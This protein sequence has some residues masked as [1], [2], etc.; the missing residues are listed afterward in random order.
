MMSIAAV[1][2]ELKTAKPDANVYFDFGGCVPT[3]VDSW[4]GSYAEP[5]I[6]WE[7]S[8]YTGNGKPPTVT[9]LMAEL[10]R[11]TD[12]REYSGWKGGEYSYSDSN[13]L[14]VD[15]CGDSTHTEIVRVEVD[16]W[17]VV[18]HTQMLES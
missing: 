10:E 13:T 5:A 16:D 8:G 1:M 3:R 11:A 14:H 9:D 18:L 6:G 15:N 2:A 7:P 4:R 17:R 12:G